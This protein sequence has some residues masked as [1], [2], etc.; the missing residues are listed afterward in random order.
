MAL[1]YLDDVVIFTPDA[2]SHILALDKAFLAHAKAGL[3]LNAQ[4]S[5][6]FQSDVKYLGFEI[7]SAEI[8]PDPEACKIIH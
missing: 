7:S 6:F 1:C 8:S 2:D 5:S 3:K 4:N